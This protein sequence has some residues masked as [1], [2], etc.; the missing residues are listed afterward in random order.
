MPT[1]SH[2]L[3]WRSSW[4]KYSEQTKADCPSQNSEN[5]GHTH[6]SAAPLCFT[7]RMSWKQTHVLK[8]PTLFC[9]NLDDVS[10]PFVK[11]CFYYSSETFPPF[12]FNSLK[13]IAIYGFDKLLFLLLSFYF[14]VDMNLW[15][16]IGF[17]NFNKCSTHNLLSVQSQ[18]KKTTGLTGAF[19]YKRSF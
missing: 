12:V 5:V 14:P 13:C 17:I 2:L 7:G 3:G 15:V 19:F 1:G 16:F 11:S 4:L 8:K 6:K 18:E 9:V 10:K